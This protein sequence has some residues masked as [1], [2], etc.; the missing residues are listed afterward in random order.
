[1]CHYIKA[2][3][4][5]FYNTSISTSLLRTS[6]FILHYLLYLT[7][8]TAVATMTAYYQKIQSTL[9]ALLGNSDCQLWAPTKGVYGN[10]QSGCGDNIRALKINENMVLSL[11]IWTLCSKFPSKH[12]F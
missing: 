4:T 1:M 8:C 3:F 6:R 9:L 12:F 10:F 7:V 11:K 2:I 5:H